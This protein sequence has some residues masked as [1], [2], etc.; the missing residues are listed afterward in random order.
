[1]NTTAIFTISS[2]NYY[3]FAK[4]LLQSV[5]EFHS[6][7]DVDLYYLLVDEKADER[8]NEDQ[9]LFKL[10]VV[11]DI[12]I[13]DYKKMAFAYDIVEFNTAVKPFFIRYLFEQGYDKVIYL[14]P[15]ILVVNRLDAA[16]NALDNNAIVVTP[17][18]LSPA[19]NLNNFIP[20]QQFKWEQSVLQRGTFNLGFIGVANTPTG[21]S[22][23]DWWSNRCYYLC[24][25]DPEQGLFVDQK[26]IDLAKVFFPS[27]SV[28]Q[29][30]GY[31]MAVWN[32]YARKMFNN[33][34]N[35]A[36][37]LVFYHF[38]SIDMN[39]PVIISKHDKSLKLE[40][41]PDLADLFQA[42][43]DKVMNN[44]H[45]YFS[46]LPYTYDFF[47][48]GRKINLLERRLYSAVA[49]N[50]PDP[51]STPSSRFY[52]TLR[53]K[54]KSDRLSD[55]RSTDSVTLSCAKTCIRTLFRLIGARRYTKVV[56]FF[57]L[58]DSFRQH[59][60]LLD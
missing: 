39:D 8:I 2:N 21:S 14:D 25:S 59:T 5:K 51:F 35:E 55:D 3:A 37:P 57:R 23:L 58:T 1:M 18:Q 11:K 49:N 60:F 31:N 24:F 44:D 54:R 9:Q 43:R 34:V 28:L 52:S 10:R 15:D 41:R 47:N 50:Y 4:T 46:K 22:F 6:A 56:L 16:L 40:D 20:Y 38:S 32:L 30:Q 33:R 27:L 19:G 42:Y 36:D 48:D 17:H 53:E 26:W 7:S 45:P 29:H 13:P 12:G